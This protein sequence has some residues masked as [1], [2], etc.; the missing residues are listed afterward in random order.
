M[1]AGLHQCLL[2]VGSCVPGS[3]LIVPLWSPIQ[4]HMHFRTPVSVSCT[5]PTPTELYRT[6]SCN[7]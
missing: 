7:R 5:P 6:T 2:W 1:R 4:V 3:A